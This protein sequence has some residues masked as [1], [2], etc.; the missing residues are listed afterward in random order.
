MQTKKDHVHAYQ[1]LVGR[2]SAGL[3]LGDTNYSEAPARRAL[4]GLVYGVVLAL[5]VGVGFWVYGLINP[6]GNM[7][8][9]KPNTI[10]VEKESG[11]RFVYDRGLLFPVVNHASAMLLK[12]A[13]AT[14]ETISRASLSGLERGAPIGILGA[15]DPVPS[16]NALVTTPWLL[17]LPHTGGGQ[18]PGQGL[19]S[20]NANPDASSTPLDEREYMWVGSTDGHQYLVWSGLKLRLA[21]PAVAVALGLGTSSPP[22]APPAWL[23]ALPDG[24]EIGPASIE[25]RGT[26]QVAGSARQVGT[27]FRQAAGNGTENFV[28]LRPDGLAPMSRTEAALLT[29]AQGESA[30]D[31]DAATMASMP[32]SADTSLTSRIPDLLTAKSMP[33][34]ERAYCLRQELFGSSVVSIPV[35]TERNFAWFGMNEQV[36]AYLKPGTGLLAASA[37]APTGAGA[38][39]DRFL[40]TDRGFKYRLADDEAIKALG[41][42]GA[43][44]RPM[45]AEVLAQIPSGPV[46][47]RAAVGPVERGRG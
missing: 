13:G 8:W 31:I 22:S 9:K 32:R 47:S 17:C 4:M 29:T 21:S 12:G 37:P 18:P 40:I 1:T 25:G 24:P 6:G 14:V 26:V 2:M 19:M 10:L 20:L 41:F 11:A 42:G 33:I 15:P 28:V 36:G 3:L 5:L 27:V 43:A 35:T 34:G 7:A 44:P 46:L 16:A 30:A 38:K 39:P 45:A 23:A